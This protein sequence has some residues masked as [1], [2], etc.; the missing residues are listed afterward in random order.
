M[1]E[2]NGNAWPIDPQAKCT[3]LCQEA[4]RATRG[5]KEFWFC[6]CVST[7]DFKLDK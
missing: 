2:E 5:M 7:A 6:V 4:D 3:H 1:H